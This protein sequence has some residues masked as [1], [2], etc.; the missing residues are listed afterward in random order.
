MS[1]TAQRFIQEFV[2]SGITHVVWLPSSELH[3]LYPDL[4]HAGI[5]LIPVCRDAEAIAI[6]AGLIWGGQKPLVMIQ[7]T[8]FFDAA[9]A[10]RGFAL[11]LR[12]PLAMLI[13]YRGGRRYGPMRDSA[14]RLLE[15]TLKTWGVAYHVLDDDHDA[16]R[17]RAGLEEARTHSRPVAFLV[18]HSPGLMETYVGGFFRTLANMFSPQAGKTSF[19]GRY[20]D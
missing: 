17:I 14:A 19:E 7:N 8:G 15:P 18:R 3:F 10:F 5:T 1:F 13:G 4:A 2:E 9:D 6:A 12:L 11:Q 20:R 16:P